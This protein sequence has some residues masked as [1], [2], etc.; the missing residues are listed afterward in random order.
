M[1]RI[2]MRMPQINYNANTRIYANDTN[3]IRSII[4]MCPICSGAAEGKIYIWIQFV[5]S[6]YFIIWSIRI[7]FVDSDY[8]YF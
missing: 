1:P 7:Q 8:V 3:I 6:D 5:D 4:W 2:I